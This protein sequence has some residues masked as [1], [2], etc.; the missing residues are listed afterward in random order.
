MT[1][2]NSFTVKQKCEASGLKAKLFF[3]LLLLFLMYAAEPE[4]E[5]ALI[6]ASA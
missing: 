6:V 1:A 5:P 2:L 3:H 4:P